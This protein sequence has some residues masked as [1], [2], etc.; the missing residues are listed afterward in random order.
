MIKY[1]TKSIIIIQLM[2][3]FDHD[4]YMIQDI[5]SIILFTDKINIIFLLNMLIQKYNETY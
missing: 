3:Q 2:L 1:I 4:N 5:Y